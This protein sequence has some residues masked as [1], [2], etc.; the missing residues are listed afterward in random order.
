MFAVMRETD[1]YTNPRFRENFWKDWRK[2]LG[3]NHVIQKLD[4]CDFT[5]IYEWN[6][7]KKKVKSNN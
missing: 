3:K 7:E 6:L 4:D 1:F 2:L 5:P